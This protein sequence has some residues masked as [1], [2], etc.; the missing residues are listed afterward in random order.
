MAPRTKHLFGG[1]ERGDGIGRLADDTDGIQLRG[2]DVRQPHDEPVDLDRLASLHTERAP[3][4]TFGQGGGDPV[5][6]E[7]AKPYPCDLVGTLSDMSTNGA[8]VFR[9]PS[10][11]PDPFV[12]RPATMA[13]QHAAYELVAAA[14]Q[15][16][17]GLVEIDES[18]IEASWSAPGA[19][20]ATMTV[21]V[22][23]A[24]SLVGMAELSDGGRAEVVVA[25][26][27]RGRGI[28]TALLR[29]TEE[30]A[31][32]LGI[33]R[34]RQI[35]SDNRSDAATMLRANGYEPTSADWI[36]EVVFDTPLPAPEVPAGIRI[37]SYEPG[38]DDRNVYRLIEDAFAEWGWP[39]RRPMTFEDW[40]RTHPGHAS[41]S[42]ELSPLAFD[43]DEIVGASIA[44]HYAG[45]DEGW[46]EQLA[47]KSSHR[48]RGIARALLQTSFLG[49]YERD[50]FRVGLAT[51][52]FTGA[53]SLYERLGMTV[54]R[55]FTSF[56]KALDDATG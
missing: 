17:D 48:H 30:Q 45:L 26:G 50:R 46:I 10:G 35:V 39:E 27:A 34:V 3:A 43:G 51:S 6:G 12:A 53:R 52:S 16:D 20:L 31:P 36:L 55:S 22:L 5:G 24:D 18:D 33:T 25:S 8:A 54:R 40:H 7:H 44:M 42:A 9:R 4:K 1:G 47:T 37:R 41:F 19:N 56:T 28:G 49:F 21:L 15:H 2:W 32:E 14:E 11:L 23:D 38:R 29:W 13:D